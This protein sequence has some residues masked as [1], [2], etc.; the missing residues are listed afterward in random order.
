MS[1]LLCSPKASGPGERIRERLEASF[2]TECLEIFHCIE[3]LSMR[4]RLPRKLPGAAVVVLCSRQDMLDIVAVEGL[5]SDLNTILVLPDDEAGTLAKA[6]RIRPR[7]LAYADTDPEVVVAVLN[8]MM[9]AH[10]KK[11]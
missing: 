6:H 1:L 10:S 2:H 7:F 11:S 3:T 9:A 8:K 4:L 5:F